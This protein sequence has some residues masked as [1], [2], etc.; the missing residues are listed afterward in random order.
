MIAPDVWVL[1]L[2]G[3]KLH[4][5]VQ[6]VGCKLDVVTYTSL[7]KVYFTSKNPSN[8]QKILLNTQKVELVEITFSSFQP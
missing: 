6:H 4:N 8:V 3:K 1:I 7:H 5:M 2:Y